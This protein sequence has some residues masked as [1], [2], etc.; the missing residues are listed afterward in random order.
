[1]REKPFPARE[2]GRE[3][4]ELARPRARDADQAG[5]LLEIVDAE[6]GR[7]A[8][9]SCGRQYVVGAGAVVADRLRAPAAEEDRAGVP[10]H[11]QQR[12]RLRYRK[13]KVL[14]RDAVRDFASLLETARVDQRAAWHGRK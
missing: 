14:R 1:M 3:A 4:P 9:R 8:R 11:R 13:L 2:R 12:A 10:Q 5:A 7:K 6:R